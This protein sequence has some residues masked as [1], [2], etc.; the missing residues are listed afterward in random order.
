MSEKPEMY[1]LDLEQLEIV[2]GGEND[3]KIEYDDECYHR[4]FTTLGQHKVVNGEQYEY[5][6]CVDCGL[7]MWVKLSEL[8][9]PA[10]EISPF[11]PAKKS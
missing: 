3:R 1:A 11:A 10:K 4:A 5:V 9:A 6:Q 7:T 8:F 2:S